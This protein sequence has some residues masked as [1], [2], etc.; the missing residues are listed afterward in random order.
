MQIKNPKASILA[1]SLIIMGIILTIAL[2]VSIVAVNDRK[3]SISANKSS[4]AFQIA[5]SGAEV[6]LQKIKENPGVTI[7]SIIS[8]PLICNGNK[9]SSPDSWEV[10]LMKDDMGTPLDCA[11]GLTDDVRKI[12]SIG[13][14]AGQA[15]RAIEVAVAAPGAITIRSESGSFSSGFV[16]DYVARGGSKTPLFLTAR[17]CNFGGSNSFGI[18]PGGTDVR[19]YDSGTGW[20]GW[21]EITSANN[22]CSADGGGAPT[23]CS[24]STIPFIT[25]TTR[26]EFRDTGWGGAYAYSVE[27]MTIAEQ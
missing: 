18:C 2:S 20:T 10:A 21:K 23:V 8:A 1:V 11:T 26:I 3:A 25:G 24:T 9:I 27:L 6:I 15:Q 13:T 4:M 12:K 19:W 17:I 14:A 22:Y 16:Y 7:G 5:D